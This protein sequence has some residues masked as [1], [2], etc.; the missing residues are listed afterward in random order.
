MQGDLHRFKEELGSHGLHFGAMTT[1]LSVLRAIERLTLRLQCECMSSHIRV[2]SLA[3]EESRKLLAGESDSGWTSVHQLLRRYL[4]AKQFLQHAKAIASLPRCIQRRPRN[5]IEHFGALGTTQITSTPSPNLRSSLSLA[6][7]NIFLMGGRGG[8]VVEL[9]ASLQGEP[10]SIPCGA[11]P[12]FRMWESCRTMSLVGGFSRGSPVSPALAFRRY[13][14]VYSPRFTLIGCQDLYVKS[15]R[16]LFTSPLIA[17]ND[18]YEVKL[19]Q[20]FFAFFWTVPGSVARNA[21]DS[22]RVLMVL[23]FG[24]G[25]GVGGSGKHLLIAHTLRRHSW[26]LTCMPAVSLLASYQGDPRSIPC[27]VTPEFHMWKS[28]RTIPLVRGVFSGIFRFPRPYPY[29]PQS[30]LS[31]LKTS[32]A[33]PLVTLATAAL[34][35]TYACQKSLFMTG[36]M[37]CDSDVEN[38]RKNDVSLTTCLPSQD[39]ANISSSRKAGQKQLNAVTQNRYPQLPSFIPV[40]LYF[41][42][43]T[44]RRRECA[45]RKIIRMRS[46]FLVCNHHE[47]RIHVVKDVER[48]STHPENSR[49]SINCVARLSDTAPLLEVLSL[50]RSKFQDAYGHDIIRTLLCITAIISLDVALLQTP[51]RK[52]KETCIRRAHRRGKT[53]MTADTALATRGKTLTTMTMKARALRRCPAM[54]R[55]SPSRTEEMWEASPG[56]TASRACVDPPSYVF[57]FRFRLLPRTDVTLVLTLSGSNYTDLQTNSQCYK[58]TE[59]LPRRGRGTNP[60]PLDYMSATLPLNYGSRAEL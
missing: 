60:R 20:N 35:S 18:T 37:T 38:V 15:R 51:C 17:K 42:N 47:L 6:P 10:G 39:D 3:F 1:S 13:S 12:E 7:P 26:S 8:V 58:R 19:L 50:H 57:F 16:N 45:D 14:T 5:L 28:C 34:L 43:S 44:R 23:Y 27:R 25:G 56:L 29:A 40:S 36:L 52:K 4:P 24:G 48:E 30:P 11:T 54:L 53:Y 59:G 9:L 2:V 41:L 21:P 49:I 55:T 33:A 22:L 31:A 46:V 32:I